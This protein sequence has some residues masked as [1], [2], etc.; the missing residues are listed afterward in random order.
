MIPQPTP[1]YEHAVLVVLGCRLVAASDM[2]PMMG[3]RDFVGF[4]RR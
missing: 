3:A 1:Q 4:S 2:Y